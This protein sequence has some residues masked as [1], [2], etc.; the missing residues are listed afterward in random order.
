[1]STLQRN[2]MITVLIIVSIL[3]LGVILGTPR[4][5]TSSQSKIQVVAA[6]NFWG[7]L[8]SQLGGDRVHVTS[9]VSDPNADPHEYEST[10]TTARGVANANYVIVNG[11]GYDSWAEKL[12]S[13]SSEPSR[14]VLNVAHLLGKKEGDNPHFWY[15]PAY[16]N[17]VVIA[18]DQNLIQIDPAHRIYY[19]HNLKT[20]TSSLQAYQQRI[21]AIRKQY[22]TTKVASTEDIFQYLA[23]AAGLNVI[24][25]SAFTQAVAEGNDP[26]TSSVATF[27]QQLTH[28]QVHM[29]VYNIQTITP[30]TSSMKK[31]AL[32]HHI[33]IVG[34]TETI[35]PPTMPFQVWMNL[36][37]TTVQNAL[38]LTKRGS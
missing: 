10:T 25:P 35:Q 7:S 38:Q 16:V 5:S 32:A 23:N 30:L 33:P 13:V 28:G 9:I 6:E 20:L 3:G 18:M 14:K 37:I 11:A 8:A 31:L 22:A 15:S 29:L 24:S 4:P 17:R 27:Q 12:L 21:I 19:L 26:P 36:E 2:I 1:M 34:V